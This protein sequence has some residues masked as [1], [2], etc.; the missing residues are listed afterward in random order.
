MS[1][2]P[3]NRGVWLSVYMDVDARTW[4]RL[5]AALPTSV[6]MVGTFYDEDTEESSILGVF[7]PEMNGKRVTAKAVKAVQTILEAFDWEGG[8]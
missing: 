3:S 7:I 2:Y 4:W 6:N 8:K 1:Q 5:R